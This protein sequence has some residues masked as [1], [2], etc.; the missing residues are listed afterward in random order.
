MA[1][2]EQKLNHA[3]QALEITQAKLCLQPL[4]QQLLEQEKGILA[5]VEKWSNVEEQV[6][7]QKSKACWIDRGDSNSKFFHA[8]WKIRSSRNAISS[9]DTETGIKLTDPLL[10]VTEEEIYA[11][12]LDMPKEKAPG[13]D[14]FPIE[15]FTRNWEIVKKEVIEAVQ[16]F[17]ST[18]KLDPTVNCTAVTL[19][20]KKQTPT[21]VKDYRPIACC[22]TIYKI[23]AKV[24]TSRLKTVIDGLIGCC[25]S[26]FIEGR[27]ILDNII[28]SHELLKG[29]NRKWISL[30]CV[31]KVDLR[32]AYD[33]LEWVFLERVLLDLRFPYK[34]VKWIMECITT[35]SYSLLLNGGLTKPFRAKRGI[36]QGDL[37][38]PYLFV[39]GME[40]DIS[41]I[42]LLNATFQKLSQASGLKANTDKCSVYMA[43]ISLTTKQQIQDLLGYSA[44]ELPFRLQ[45]IK[46]VL[47]GLQT[48]WAQFFILPK[49]VLKMVE[50]ICR[51]FLW[52]GSATISKKALNKAAIIK[53]LWAVGRKKD[54]LWIKWIHSFYIKRGNLA[55][56]PLPKAATW[57]VK[58]IL[59]TRE[60][61][62]QHQA[63]QGDLQSILSGTLLN[64]KFSIKKMYAL[65][66]PHY[67]KVTWKSIMLQPNV[68]PRYKFTLWLA[69]QGRLATVD[70]LQKFGIIVPPD[71]IFCGQTQETLSHL[72]FECSI[73]KGLWCRLL[74][75]LGYTRKIGDWKYEVKWISHIA[76]HKSGHCSITCCIFGMLVALVWRERNLLRFQSTQF[77]PDRLCREIA[78][79]IHIQGRNNFKWQRALAA[80]NSYP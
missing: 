51:S 32:K 58:K 71:C 50:A 40:A 8:Q 74:V 37:M 54:C 59:G 46:S 18:R 49:K 26:A 67:T 27:H 16:N 31:L 68:H 35:V 53:Q 23:I 77:L 6:L 7:R 79:P 48:Y 21:H 80:M 3:R 70:R 45:M 22:T 69:I 19:V 13:V 42:Q 9:V 66:M 73:T 4:D 2:Y 12:I 72:Y 43:G 1:A 34:F 44:G 61:I 64:G 29:Y 52:T 55:D 15:F 14:G 75:W 63:M 38:S 57:V 24:L 5:D 65:L 60:L 47:F 17:F 11:A 62:L 28:F 76:R 56:S 33:T 36:R 10:D 78:Q 39:I 20:P 30:R 41:S 25:Q